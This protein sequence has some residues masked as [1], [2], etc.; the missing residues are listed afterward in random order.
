MAETELTSDDMPDN[1]GA[2]AIARIDAISRIA[3]TAWLGLLSVLVFT[4]I[5]ILGVEDVDFF[6]I[7]RSTKLP[8]IG[9]AIPITYFFGAGAT[10]VTALYIY[11]HLY[12]ELLWA[13]LGRAPASIK[14]HPLSETVFPWLITE[15]ALRRRDALRVPRGEAACSVSRS[16]GWLG[17]LISIL[18]VWGFG[19]VILGMFWW[20]LLPA[21]YIRLSAGLGLLLA[22]ALWTAW[23][24][25]RTANQ[26]LAGR[27]GNGMFILTGSLFFLLTSLGMALQTINL[28]EL[29][30]VSAN[31]TGAQLV[32]RPD[33]WLD[34]DEAE[35]VYRAKWAK[36]ENLIYRDL[37][38]EIPAQDI[39]ANFQEDLQ[40]ALVISEKLDKV[41][42]RTNWA[43][44]HAVALADPFENIDPRFPEGEFQSSWRRRREIYL[45]NLN[46]P[47]LDGRDLRNAR[48]DTA[49][50][51]GVS[52]QKIRLEGAELTRSIMEG[53]NLKWANLNNATLLVARLENADLSGA[54]LID[55]FLMGARLGHAKLQGAN[56]NGANL[57]LVRL[58]GANLSW[59]ELKKANLS[60][61]WLK[62][63]NIQ[64]AKLDGA[65]FNSTRLE[66]AILRWTQLFGSTEEIL[67]LNS[68]HIQYSDFFA[69]ALRLVD[70][71]TTDLS[72]L[73]YFENSFGDATVRLPTG[74]MPPCQWGKKILNDTE[75]FGRWR[76]WLEISPTITGMWGDLNKYKAIAPPPDCKWKEEE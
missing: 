42:Y 56:L 60:A 27:E 65:N 41:R 31:L 64:F 45:S 73:Y 28:I 49:F 75:Y 51:P 6:S 16:M 8:L 46:K 69:T 10:L 63:A 72:I 48:M 26:L 12:L 54:Q 13:A 24:S 30:P 43:I 1:D 55:T 9:V 76:G 47:V 71:S 18:F 59:V 62:R 36:R 22:I 29:N 50:L 23:R 17:G 5:T 53:A 37:F 57:S 33:D 15:W 2:E 68:S 39:E 32:E 40:A 61:A 66:S 14:G 35:K 44:N 38:P 70:L 3:R 74:K 11:L 7:D 25:W 4:G 67:D 52:M 19:L 34:R 21:H 20:F 58:E